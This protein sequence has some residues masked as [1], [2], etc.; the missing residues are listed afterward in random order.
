MES[1]GAK[2]FIGYEHVVSE[3]RIGG[4]LVD[5]ASVSSATPGQHVEVILNQTPFYAESGGQLGD[6]GSI[7][8]ENGAVLEVYDVQSPVPGLFVHRATVA[9]G[10]VVVG[11]LAQGS[12]NLARRMAISR[13]HT[14]THMIHKAF[15]E[16]LGE[17]A[18][19]MGSENSP[20]RLRFD[21]PSVGAV[22][23]S[24]LRDVEERVNHVLLEDL[25]VT[26]EYMSQDAARKIGAMA[27]FG[28]K[29]GDS[30]RVVSVG[31]WAKELCGGTHTPRTGHLGVVKFL[32]EGSIGAGVRRVEAL[33][34]ADAYG[35]LAKEHVLLAQLSEMLKVRP[36]EVAQRVESL[37]MK[38]KE[39][40]KDLEK[41]R[42]QQLRS[43]LND[44][45]H[46][47]ERNGVFI[48]RVILPVGT[49]ASDARDI[50]VEL[51]GSFPAEASGVV[52]VAGVADGRVSV[53]VSAT[54]AAVDSG[55]HAGKI[56]SAM[57]EKL[58]G[59]GGGKSDLAQGGGSNT[60]AIPLA[61]AL[62]EELL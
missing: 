42:S 17:T 29:Y 22:P 58:D 9:D 45:I 5:G 49:P 40:E 13:A 11:A 57:V 23:D 34:G 43:Q 24:V 33:V 47:S 10:E 44:L 25:P 18:T 8:L 35:F 1:A 61:M 27:L 37:V 6:H 31:D 21:F 36:D 4:L 2:P 54:A 62:V 50:A 55:V 38:L 60:Q 32:S 39:A 51:K 15:R 46:T 53:V 12:V 14:A 16:L 30:V 20:G 59:K 28:E 48:K 52:V 41:V 26:A 7:T 56:L 19:Q 3:S